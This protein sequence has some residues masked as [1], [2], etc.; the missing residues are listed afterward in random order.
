M[1]KRWP[2]EAKPHAVGLMGDLEGIAQEYADRIGR[3]MRGLRPEY[4]ADDSTL[5]C[6]WDLRQS[7]LV[8]LRS[9]RRFKG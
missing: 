8:T 6:L 2:I 1:L 9:R 7:T 3:E 5:I 4:D